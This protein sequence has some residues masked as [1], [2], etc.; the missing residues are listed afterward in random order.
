VARG[1]IERPAVPTPASAVP[2]TGRLIRH[3][4]GAMRMA[5]NFENNSANLK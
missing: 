5:S 4:S 2:M 1:Y 3:G